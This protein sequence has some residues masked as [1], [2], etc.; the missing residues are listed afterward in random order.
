[1]GW[2]CKFDIIPFILIGVF[3]GFFLGLAASPAICIEDSKE[4]IIDEY[5]ITITVAGKISGGASLID[6][7][8]IEDT[9]GHLWLLEKDAGLNISEIS[10][11]HN[12]IINW[13]WY[14][15]PLR[16][17]TSRHISKIKPAGDAS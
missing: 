12:Y 3:I 4:D 1:M 15:F 9:D 2:I 6:Y 13:C 8:Y 10:I 17:L 7:P 16:S 5:N 11:G 14:L